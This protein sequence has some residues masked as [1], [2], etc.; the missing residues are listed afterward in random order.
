MNTIARLILGMFLGALF[1]TGLIVYM[2]LIGAGAEI[3]GFTQYTLWYYIVS[4]CLCVA[5]LIGSHAV[6]QQKY[7]MAVFV[8]AVIMVLNIGFVTLNDLPSGTNPFTLIQDSVLGIAMLVAKLMMY[9]GPG[10]L[11]VFYA[12]IAFENLPARKAKQATIEGWEQAGR[13]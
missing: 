11:T 9:V 1:A 6:R 3:L 13:E 5:L 12:F 4:F 8:V 2:T 10:A 7:L